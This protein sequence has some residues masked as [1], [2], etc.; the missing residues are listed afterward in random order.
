[1]KLKTISQIDFIF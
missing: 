1:M